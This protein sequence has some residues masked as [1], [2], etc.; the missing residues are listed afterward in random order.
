MFLDFKLNYMN[1]MKTYY[2]EMLDRLLL[3]YGRT[4]KLRGAK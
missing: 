3:V 1:N 4:K 2:G